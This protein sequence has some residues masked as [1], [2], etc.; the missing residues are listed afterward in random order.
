MSVSSY[1]R[2]VFLFLERSPPAMMA[3][4]LLSHIGSPGHPAVPPSYIPYLPH[5]IR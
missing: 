4:Y 5:G 2:W 1:T 3:A